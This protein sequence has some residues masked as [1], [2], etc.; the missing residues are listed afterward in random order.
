MLTK[1]VA[2]LKIGVKCKHLWYG[3]SYGGFYAFPNLLDEN[4]IVYSFGIGEDISFDNSIIN[5]HNCHVF[6]FDPT[7]KSINW[8]RS[9]KT[10]EKFHFYEY[11]INSK[12]GFVDFYPPKNSEHVSG[13]MATLDHV[14]VT[15]KVTV[16]MKSIVDI[17][18]ELGHSHIDV[19]KMDIEGAEYDVI[20]DILN[21]KIS[22]HQILIEFHDRFFEDGHRKT[23]QA[24]KKLNNGGFKI[25]A[26]SD[27]FEEISFI[28]ENVLHKDFYH[29]ATTANVRAKPVLN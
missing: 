3:S 18:D 9:Q 13:S 10:H 16:E 11:G 8:I 14:D 24:V 1:K 25:F 28:N 21:A 27:S 12:S 17:M 2:H 20:E 29:N 4:S 22:V 5:N 6:G 19:L 15:R 7:P 26:N 23:E